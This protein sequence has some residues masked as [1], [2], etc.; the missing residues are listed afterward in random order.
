MSSRGRK[1]KEKKLNNQIFSTER[2][3]CVP[4]SFFT[5]KVSFN[6]VENRY[7]TRS[8]IM[9]MSFLIQRCSHGSASYSAI[10]RSLQLSCQTIVKAVRNLQSAGIIVRKMKPA[11]KVQKD[12]DP[13]EQ[14]HA[15]EVSGLTV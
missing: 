8:E 15:E 3:I 1:K 14:K 12:K 5:Q 7:L 10:A 11:P 13:K 9:V 4:C 6:N 2:Y